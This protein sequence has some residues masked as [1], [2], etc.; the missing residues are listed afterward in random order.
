M[1]VGN[2]SI[3]EAE[4]FQEAPH[5][6]V[7]AP[8]TSFQAHGLPLQVGQEVAKQM[9]SQEAAMQDRNGRVETTQEKNGQVAATQETNGKEV[10][11]KEMDNQ[12]AAAHQMVIED[13]RMQE[14]HAAQCRISGAGEAC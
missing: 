8:E 5:Y 6:E 2:T 3:S 7:V 9:D 11:A 1:E 12:E 14:M 4:I 13:V 10:L